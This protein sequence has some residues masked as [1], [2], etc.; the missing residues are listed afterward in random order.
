MADP[1][2]LRVLKALTASLEQITTANGYQHD[3]TGKVFRGRDIFGYS[4]PLPMVSILE[5]IREIEQ[6]PTAKPNPVQHGSWPLLIQGF[7]EDDDQNPSDP[8]HL[9][10]ADV[11]RRLI[12]ERIRDRSFNILG[13]G[14]TVTGLELSQGVVRPP[15][16]GVS[17]KAYFWLRMTLEL[18]EDC[19]NPYA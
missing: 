19:T 13:M 9:L 2:R 16:E 8:A 17:N 1:T 14:D 6:Q 7:C 4:D 15:D 5:D 11:K 18:V 12:E 3:L 10:L